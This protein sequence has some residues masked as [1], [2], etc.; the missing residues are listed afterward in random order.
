MLKN[1]TMPGPYVLYMGDL[2]VVAPQKGY[3]ENDYDPEIN[4]KGYHL[5]NTTVE[6]TRGPKYVEAGEFSYLSSFT[7][8]SVLCDSLQDFLV[9]GD[10]SFTLSLLF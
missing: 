8:V 1:P 10:D 2:P 5:L 9:S 4:E 6:T 3:T 7:G